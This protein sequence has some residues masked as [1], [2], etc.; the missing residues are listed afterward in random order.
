MI[1]YESLFKTIYSVP[2]TGI[3]IALQA[4]ARANR[5]QPKVALKCCN[6]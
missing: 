4:K 5:A 6:S 3:L 2:G 1:C